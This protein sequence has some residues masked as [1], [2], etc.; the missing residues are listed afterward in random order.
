MV[1][2][3]KYGLTGP[4]EVTDGMAEPKDSRTIVVR[5]TTIIREF[6]KYWTSFSHKLSSSP[7]EVPVAVG[8]VRKTDCRSHQLVIPAC[9]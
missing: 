2:Y 9:R 6:T 4:T 1:K 5:P 7:T 8:W 3:S